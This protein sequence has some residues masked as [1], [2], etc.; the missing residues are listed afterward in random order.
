MGR[1]DLT[2]ILSPVEI[3]FP[4]LFFEMNHF[5]I[6]NFDTF[7]AKFI[8]HIVRIGKPVFA[9]QYPRSI[10]DPMGGDVSISRMML[11]KGIPY[12][13]GRSQ[14]E[15]IGYYSVS[16]YPADWDFTDHIIDQLVV[17]FPQFAL[18]LCFKNTN[19]YMESQPVQY[20]VL[21]IMTLTDARYFS[22]LGV[23]YLHFDLNPESP[24]SISQPA[25]QAII[26]WVEGSD[27]VCSFDHLFDRDAIRQIVENPM[28]TGVMSHYPD[29]LDHV[30]QINPGLK[31]F[32][33]VDSPEEVDKQLSLTGVI[34]PVQTAYL[35]H[36]FL[37][38]NGP[39][40][41]Q[42]AVQNGVTRIAIHPGSE[43]EVGIKDY[44]AWDRLLYQEF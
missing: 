9:G 11:A 22:A 6:L 21:G 37:L 40:E 20:F 15:V 4:Q 7:P 10:D 2:G 1:T 13:P 42:G 8:G 23:E 27:I 26:E 39:L 12:H 34:C 19:I 36:G 43:D 18:L 3:R 24:Y 38:C 5:V 16:G 44:E 25:W 28:V 32:Q 29:L 14:G 31:L 33:Q 35:P 17:G 41:A 30:S